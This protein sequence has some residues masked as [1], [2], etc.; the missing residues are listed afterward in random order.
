[1]R[2]EGLNCEIVSYSMSELM[3]ENQGLVR[4]NG[5]DQMFMLMDFVSTICNYNLYVRS[6]TFMELK[7]PTPHSV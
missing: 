5:K 1:M 7:L 3:R 4:T 6:L 2:V